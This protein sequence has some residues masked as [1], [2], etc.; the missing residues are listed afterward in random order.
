M[1]IYEFRCRQCHKKS[2]FLVNLSG[3]TGALSC[4]SCGSHDMARAISGFAYHRRAGAGDGDS[5]SSSAA[6]YYSDPRNVGCWAEKQFQKAGMEVPSQ[7]KE[8]IQKAREGELPA[9][10][11]DLEGGNPDAA[12]S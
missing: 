6:D 10:L 12:Y 5:S 1:P 11:K 9:S 7:I 4:P 8:T 3:A 2:S